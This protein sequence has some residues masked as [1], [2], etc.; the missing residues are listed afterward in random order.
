MK[1]LDTTDGND[2]T[3]IILS[4]IKRCIKLF[5]KVLTAGKGALM[6]S[7]NYYLGPLLQ[8]I[9]PSN[10]LLVEGS[11]DKLTLNEDSIKKIKSFQD[12]FFH[13]IKPI[14]K[15]VYNKFSC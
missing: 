8:A 2:Y 7:K 13:K 14:Q 15:N 4:Y 3:V 9:D 11:T 1:E 5:L 10:L 12:L 6:F